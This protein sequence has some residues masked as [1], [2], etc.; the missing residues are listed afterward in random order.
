MRTRRLILV[1]PTVLMGLSLP[2][3]SAAGIEWA[4]VGDAGNPWGRW[5]GACHGVVAEVYRI[6]KTEVTNA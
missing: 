2:A 4:T 6:S 3:D 1:V 5:Y